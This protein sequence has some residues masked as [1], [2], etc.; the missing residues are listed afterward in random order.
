MLL[1]IMSR[2]HF[3]IHTK[4]FIEHLVLARANT[5]SVAY[6]SYF[7]VMKYNTDYVISKIGLNLSPSQILWQKNNFT[8]HPI[9]LV[10]FLS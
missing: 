6:H 2:I 9:S 10:P 5:M 1:K 4:I 8:Q 7:N 3:F